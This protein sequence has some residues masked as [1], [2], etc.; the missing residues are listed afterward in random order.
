VKL[1]ILAVPGCPNV[2]TLQRR[3]AV[4]LAGRADVA[5]TSEVIDTFEQAV[6]RGMDGSPTLLVDGVDPFSAQG[7]TPSVSCR[8]YR[9]ETGQS[10]GAPSVTQLRAA[11][12]GS[13]MPVPAGTAENALVEED[14][15]SP[16]AGVASVSA[17]GLRVWRACTTAT[18]GR[19]A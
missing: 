15:C 12:D 11:V 13:G 1:E 5:L 2:V 19:C 16:D 8:L 14:C 4:V 7:Q 9:D 10:S 17:E 3:L 6:A 18:D